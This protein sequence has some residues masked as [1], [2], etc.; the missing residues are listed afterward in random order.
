MPDGARKITPGREGE[1]R[2]RI[3]TAQ[4]FRV[5]ARLQQ[6]GKLSG[7]EQFHHLILAV[8]PAH[9]GALCGLGAIRRHQGKFGDAVSLLRRAV[10][11]APHSADAQAGLGAALAGLNRPEE[12][13][14]CYEKALAIDPAHAGAH[15]D[16][17]NALCRL[18]RPE[19]AIGHY[20]KVI[21]VRPDFA[22]AHNNLGNVLLMRGRANEALA[23]FGR[24]I[25]LKP[26][27]AE[28]HCNLGS[29]MQ[30][31]DRPGLALA[32]YVKALAI[33]PDF[34][35]AHYGAGISLQA[36]GRLVEAGQAFETAVKLSPRRAE[37]HLSLAHAKPFAAG[38]PR[39]AAL[40][41]LSSD[42]TSLGEDG[43][44]A[45]H[46]TLG[47]AFADL[48]QHRQSI[49]HLLEG[50]ALKRRRLA[51]DETKTLRRFE[52]IRTTFTRELMRESRGGDPSPVPVFVVGMPRS[53]T[54]LIEQILASHSKVFG[55]G[56][57]GD[58]RRTAA[59]VAG[60]NDASMAFADLLPGEALRQ[61]GSRYVARIRTL[62]P[63]ADR[64]VDKMPSNFDLLGLIHLALPN[65]R[66]IHARRDPVD[67]CLSCFSILFAGDQPHTYDLGELGRHYRAY[68]ALMAHWRVVL[69]DGVM[70]EVDYEDVVDD[71]EREARRIIAHC[72]L[73][74]EDSCLAFHK[75]QRSVHT[76]SAGQVRRPIYRSSIGRWRPYADAL[77]PLL[78]ALDATA[79]GDA[80]ADVGAHA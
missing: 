62:A 43:R 32:H 25:A 60:S 14:A 70:L 46:F 8:E 2:G 50:N 1:H 47:K 21:A 64:I 53:G 41:A 13:I 79:D 31:L 6:Q 71:L 10:D 4:V 57:I 48:G 67:T 5:A 33:R 3:D 24:A 66:I 28:A 63:A 52:R 23:H 49:R 19:A 11:A 37:Y 45:L 38:D 77:R 17:G 15:H 69:P 54:T 16:L 56:E 78:Q 20:A 7:A 73:D 72:G 76:A 65:A 22:E 9:L 68:A 39:L 75:T 27:Y 26:S 44:I 51:Y 30:T 55:A 80:R 12:A 59:Y 74:W 36:L 34:A 42:I 61:L 18:K 29:A 58:L 40:E 35:E